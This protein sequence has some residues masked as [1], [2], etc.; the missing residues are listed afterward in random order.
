MVHRWCIKHGFFVE[1]DL[2][3]EERGRVVDFAHHSL[4]Y[5]I[6]LKPSVRWDNRKHYL[7][8][9]KRDEARRWEWPTNWREW[10]ED[11]E[12]VHYSQRR[13]TKTDTTNT[14]SNA[15]HQCVSVQGEDGIRITA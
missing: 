1:E 5:S 11:V 14:C 6:R 15:A 2:S 8:A 7:A 13:V 9:K 4:M 12:K 3:T 10:P